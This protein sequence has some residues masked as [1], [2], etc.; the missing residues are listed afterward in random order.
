V[1]IGKCLGER[2]TTEVGKMSGADTIDSMSGGIAGA[3]TLEQQPPVSRFLSNI[4]GTLISVGGTTKS[5]KEI[6][7]TSKGHSTGG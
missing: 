6:G 4:M 7:T 3:K 5:R 1:K 2:E